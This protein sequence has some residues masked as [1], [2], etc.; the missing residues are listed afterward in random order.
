MA[1]P[2]RPPQIARE[3]LEAWEAAQLAKFALRRAGDRGWG[4]FA[5]SD[6][7][8]GDKIG[9]YR[10]EVIDEAEL[11]R[12]YGDGLAPYVLHFRGQTYVDAIREPRCLAGFANDPRGT[13][14]AANVRIDSRGVMRA[15][16]YIAAG[17][18][19]LLD[20]G[21]FYWEGLRP[22]PLLKRTPKSKAS[23]T[24]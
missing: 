2:V 8:R 1:S 22:G 21:E 19:V 4:V 9:V 24:G 7:K 23:R 6:V 3:G 13:G 11:V 18:E 12:R 10:G 17:K 5:Q 16:R 15:T 20:Y 14:H